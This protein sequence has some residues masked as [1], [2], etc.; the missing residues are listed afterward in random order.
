MLAQQTGI[1]ARTIYRKV[2]RFDELGMQSLFEADPVDDRRALPSVVRRAIAELQ[3]EYP[4][5]RA[6]ELATICH[7]RFNR[8]PSPHTIN[9]AEAQGDPDA[10]DQL[11]DQFQIT[12]VEPGRIWLAGL[13]D[14]R[15]RGPIQLPEELSHRCQVGWTISGVIGR[16]GRRWQLLEVW[17]V[18]P[19]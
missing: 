10:A 11:E 17:N 15:E 18:Y 12:R 14:G 8:R 2:G 9:F 16:G 19:L 6:T 7:I 5:F 4:G 1:S 13:L 3:A